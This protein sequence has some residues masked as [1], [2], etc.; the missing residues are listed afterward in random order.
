[1]PATRFCTSV[2]LRKIPEIQKVGQGMTSL[3]FAGFL[4]FR[5]GQVYTILISWAPPLPGPS[6]LMV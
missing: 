6:W 1:M 2:W 4:G 5:I 3:S